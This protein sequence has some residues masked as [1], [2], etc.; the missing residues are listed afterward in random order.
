MRKKVIYLIQHMKF[1]KKVIL[2]YNIV[3]EISINF[4]NLNQ[5]LNNYIS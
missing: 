3:Y 2:F 4:I 5:E 1:R